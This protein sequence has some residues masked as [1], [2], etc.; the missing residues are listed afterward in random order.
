MGSFVGYRVGAWLADRI[1]QRNLF[2]I[3][4]IGVFAIVLI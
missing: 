3:F 4:W 2:L 1:G